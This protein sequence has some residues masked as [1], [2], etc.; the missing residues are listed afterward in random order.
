MFPLLKVK[1]GAC[2]T[3]RIILKRPDKRCDLLHGKYAATRASI[4]PLFLLVGDGNLAPATAY[5][6]LYL[7]VLVFMSE[8]WSD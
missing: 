1:L 8:L 7:K 6:L 4:I 5:R 3:R 2:H